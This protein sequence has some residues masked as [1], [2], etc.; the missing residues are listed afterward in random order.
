MG[1]YGDAFNSAVAAELRAQ[2]A[3]GKKTI[4]EVVQQSGI[5]KSAVLNYMNGK[6]DVPL[7][8]LVELCRVL[9]VSPQTI[10]DRAEDAVKQH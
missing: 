7:P 8:A 2:R 3:R 10:F 9:G 6:R 4:D 5:S 1:N